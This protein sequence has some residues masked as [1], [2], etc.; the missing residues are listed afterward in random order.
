MI[1]QLDLTHWNHRVRQIQKL[2]P[3]EESCSDISLALVIECWWWT[4]RLCYWWSL[5]IPWF[6]DLSFLSSVSPKFASNNQASP[7]SS[8]LSPHSPVR[9]SRRIKGLSS[10]NLPPF[11][12]CFMIFV[13]L[14]FTRNMRKANT[15]WSIQ[16]LSRLVAS[17]KT[18]PIIKSF[19]FQ[20]I[21]RIKISFKENKS[22][23]L[24]HPIHTCLAH[25]PFWTPK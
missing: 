1:E 23:K 17:N 7:E 16:V 10:K 15:A 2:T 12:F 13:F 4:S 22:V 14:P 18:L 24:S 19:F 8:G 21:T 20:N 3:D 5:S 11:S 9:K 25:S 6:E